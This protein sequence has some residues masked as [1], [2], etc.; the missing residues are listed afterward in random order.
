M[1]TLV[2]NKTTPSRRDGVLPLRNVQDVVGRANRNLNVK[3]AWLAV[4]DG[5]Q[6]VA[7][8]IKLCWL[9]QINVVIRNMSAAAAFDSSGKSY[10]VLVHGHFLPYLS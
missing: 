4:N 9:S 1:S 10:L 7:L 2:V 8:L 5:H 6:G 3:L